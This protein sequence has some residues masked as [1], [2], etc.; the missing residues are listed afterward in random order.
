[1]FVSFL[2]SSL[3]WYRLSKNLRTQKSLTAAIG[4]RSRN[5]V[6]GLKGGMGLDLGRERLL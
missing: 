3:L 2:V 4:I 1:M 6:L 5:L